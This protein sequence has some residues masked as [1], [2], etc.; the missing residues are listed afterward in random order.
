MFAVT[1]DFAFL[2]IALKM[3]DTQFSKE[4]RKRGVLIA[5]FA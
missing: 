2:D 4:L 5:F 1:V 3:S